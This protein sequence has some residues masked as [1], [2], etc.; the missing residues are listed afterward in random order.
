MDKVINIS[1]E[2][3]VPSSN[4]AWVVNVTYLFW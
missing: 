1:F 2:M 3:K 4:F